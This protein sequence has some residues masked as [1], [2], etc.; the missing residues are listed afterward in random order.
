M[1]HYFIYKSYMPKICFPLQPFG[2][3]KSHVYACVFQNV[4]IG[5]MEN[6]VFESFGPLMLNFDAS[7]RRV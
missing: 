7:S 6:P 5:Q 1:V 4:E 2:K 3:M